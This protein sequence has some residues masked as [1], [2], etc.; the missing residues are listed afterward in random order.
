MW[1][2]KIHRKALNTFLTNISGED[3]SGCPIKTKPTKNLNHYVW[4]MLLKWN[5]CRYGS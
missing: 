1:G 3:N 4:S 2:Q 5:I